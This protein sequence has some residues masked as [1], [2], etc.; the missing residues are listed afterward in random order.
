MLYF[1]VCI[2]F[3][4]YFFLFE[5]EE[6][7]GW[8]KVEILSIRLRDA[9]AKRMNGALEAGQISRANKKK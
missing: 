3:F 5:F 6:I 9:F 8:Q 4:F 1:I 7:V 2:V